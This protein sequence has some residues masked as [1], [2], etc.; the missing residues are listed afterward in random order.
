[1]VILLSMVLVE[2]WCEALQARD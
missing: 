2:Y 1:L